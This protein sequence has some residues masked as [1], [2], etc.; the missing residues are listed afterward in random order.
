MIVRDDRIVADRNAPRP[1]AP[2]GSLGIGFEYS[3][4]YF[5][6]P[7]YFRAQALTLKAP[8]CE[9]SKGRAGCDDALSVTMNPCAPA[10]RLTCPQMSDGS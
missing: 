9:Q 8:G 6:L 5:A 10:K 1:T 4:I 3:T 2:F 7:F